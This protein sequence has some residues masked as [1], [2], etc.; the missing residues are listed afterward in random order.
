MDCLPGNLPLVF[1]AIILRAGIEVAVEAREVAGRDFHTNTMS[2]LENVAN[3]PEI[4][5][6]F[7][8]SFQAE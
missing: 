1:Q 2:G 8:D 4:N 5:L 6:V 3:Y 7:V